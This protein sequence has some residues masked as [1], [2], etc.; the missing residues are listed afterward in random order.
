MAKGEEIGPVEGHSMKIC[1]PIEGNQGLKSKIYGH[2]GSAPGFM[3][4]D[5]ENGD[6]QFIANVNEHHEHGTCNPLKMLQKTT[7][8]A[9]ACSGMGMRAVQMLNQS[10]IKV[11]FSNSLFVEDLLNEYKDGRLKDLTLELSCKQHNCH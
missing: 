4:C 10:G 5:I 8:D 9:V 7:F 2:F 3:I 11:L 6:N 1:I